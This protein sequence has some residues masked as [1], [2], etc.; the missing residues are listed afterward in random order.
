MKCPNCKN[1]TAEVGR[2]WCREC[3]DSH[4][5][6]LHGTSLY[7]K[8][9]REELDPQGFVQYL[10]AD[11]RFMPAYEPQAE[12]TREREQGKFKAVQSVRAKKI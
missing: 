9:G 4:M 8:E 3:L 12:T 6:G 2:A 11:A 7:G 5:A 1:R 10:R